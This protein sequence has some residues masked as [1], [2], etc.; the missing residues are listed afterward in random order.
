MKALSRSGTCT[1]F[2]FKY[3]HFT[4]SV[5][6]LALQ[7]KPEKDS[8]SCMFYLKSWIR[9]GSQDNYQL[10]LNVENHDSDDEKKPHK[11]ICIQQKCKND[12]LH[13]LHGVT[14]S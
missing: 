14:I 6:H 12:N 7:T 9:E 8:S 5:F 4:N 13:E 3:F 1:E 2:F 11:C 10:M